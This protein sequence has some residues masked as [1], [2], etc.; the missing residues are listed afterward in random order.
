MA[1]PTGVTADARPS[2]PRRPRRGEL[3]ELAS[4]ASPTAAPA[5]R[6]PSGYVVFVEGA[7]PGDAVRAEVTKSKRD[8]AQRARRRGPRAE[9]GP[10][11]AALRPRGRRVPG[12]ALADAALRAPARAQAASW[13][14]TRSRRLG[15]L[16]GFELEPIVA[17]DGPLALPQQD[18]VLVRPPRTGGRAG[19][20]LVLGFH[21]RGRWDRVNDARDCMLASERNNAVRNLVRDWCAA[22]GLAAYDRRTQTGFLRNLVVREGRRTGDLQVRLVTSP[23]SFDVGRARRRAARA[24]PRGGVPLDAHDRGRGGHPRRDD[25]G[26]RAA[27]SAS[28]EQLGGLRFQHLAGG[29][30]PDQHR[31]GGAP[32]RARVRLRR[33]A[34]HASACTTSSA[35][36]A[37]S[38]WR[39]RCAPARCGASRS[40]R[41]RSR[42][43]S[44]NA[45]A[46]RDRQRALLRRRRPR[47][48]PAAR[49]A[50]AAPRRRRRR[51]APRRAVQEGRAPAARD[52]ARGAS[53]T[54]PAIRRRSRP[55][56]RQMVDAGYRLVKVRAVDMFP[57][58]PHIE[59]VALFERDGGRWLRLGTRGL[60]RRRRPRPGRRAR[61]SRSAARDSATPR[62]GR[63]TTRCASGLETVAVF[64]Q[65]APAARRRRRRAGAR[66]PSARRTSRQRSARW[67]STRRGCGSGSAPGSRSARSA[68][69]ARAST[70]LRA[71]L[72]ADRAD[73]GR[74]DGAEDVR[75]GGSA[76]PTACSSTG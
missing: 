11:P 9:P 41:R 66:P 13:S 59:C 21:A 72:P 16:D 35:A 19:G 6:A 49:R 50:R 30:L 8:Y 22:Q 68:S 17:A 47:R 1:S 23:G 12:L 71:A 10:G 51:P 29:L 31:D 2:A 15:G 25:G 43:R 69:C 63:T 20:T 46:E 34:R 33:P 73:R 18:G 54:S 32:L 55:N 52:A 26:R 40:S 44:R 45:R 39:S 38:A 64:A 48:D 75:A 62:C 5:S 14:T 74:R 67:A 3:L 76:R 24:L 27:T 70:A 53:S 28:T 65:A 58:T 36:S 61:R 4:R 42:T 56:A 7:F 57:H 37:R 60:R